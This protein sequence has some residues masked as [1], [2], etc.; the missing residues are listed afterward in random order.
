MSQFYSQEKPVPEPFLPIVPI[1]KRAKRFIHC[2]IVAMF[3]LLLTNSANAQLGTY[4]FTDQDLRDLSQPESNV[5]TQ[6]AN[7]LFSA[8][9]TVNTTCKL[10]GIISNLKT[11][12]RTA[13]SI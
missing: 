1:Y 5:A 2:C 9:T 12:M 10:Q 8:F 4:D 3:C 6:P 11:G 7:A 13:P